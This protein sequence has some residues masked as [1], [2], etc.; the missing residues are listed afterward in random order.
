MPGKN[1][2]GQ[3]QGSE[4]MQYGRVA[5][6][7]PLSIRNCIDSKPHIRNQYNVPEFKTPLTVIRHILI[8]TIALSAAMSADAQSFTDNLQSRQQ[9]KGNV[10]V[11]QSTEIDELVNGKKNATKTKEQ[12][13]AEKK[14]ARQAE[15]DAKRREKEARKDTKNGKRASSQQYVPQ[16]PVQVAPRLPEE[17]VVAKTQQE[18]S[19]TNRTKT[20]L[21]KRVKI[22]EDGKPVTHKVMKTVMY[23]GMKKVNGYRVQVFSGGNKRE[24]RNAAEQIGHRVKASFPEQPVYVHFY[25]PRWA[26]RVGNFTKKEDA[27]SLL[28]DIKKL[29]FKQAVVIECKVTVRNYQI[30]E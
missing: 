9:G 2:T 30:M 16:K 1:E 18:L 8:I 25:S 5:G 15:K 4:F 3:V 11:K 14:A 27:Y 20:K 28:K 22:G 7:R 6:H 23:N 26:C 21:V 10:S 12:L 13:K 29:G 19:R 17:K 24:D